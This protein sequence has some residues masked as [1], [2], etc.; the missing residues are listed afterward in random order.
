MISEDD[1]SRQ[2]PAV[3]AIA[4]PVLSMFVLTWM[5]TTLRGIYLD[6]ATGTS[7]LQAEW[8][9][10]ILVAAF[11]L[12]A[13]LLIFRLTAVFV[14]DGAVAHAM[15]R[16]V[17]RILNDMIGLFFGMVAVMICVQILA[18]QVFSGFLAL[19]G[20]IGIV[21]GLA[22]R[23]IILD[24]FSG[25]S[26]NME[27]A[28]QIGDWITVEDCTIEYTGWVDQINWRTTDRKSVV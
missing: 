4:V 19:S 22:L 18:G 6:E 9:D 26:T 15:K 24:I 2:L 27:A 3:R 28:F 12:T 16:P 11:I 7:P 14:I 23:P 5:A 13:S 17:P 8:Y 21:V 1:E 25:L 10:K 20:I